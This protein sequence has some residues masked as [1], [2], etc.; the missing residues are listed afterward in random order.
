MVEGEK[1]DENEVVVETQCEDVVENS[2]NRHT[3]LAL[4]KFV[5]IPENEVRKLQGEVESVLRSAKAHGTILLASEGINGTICYPSKEGE[6]DSVV[7]FLDNHQYFKGLRRRP[8]FAN[9]NVFHRLKVKVKEEIV[10]MGD[11]VADEDESL[12]KKSSNPL[13]S[14]CQ[15]NDD[16]HKKVDPTKVVGTYVKPGKEWDN[17]LLDPDVV[18]I[19]TRNK[20]EIE[21]G[22][23]QNAI[24]PHTDN[25]KQFPDWLRRFADDRYGNNNNSNDSHNNDDQEQPKKYQKFEPGD[26]TDTLKLTTTTN[27]R[28]KAPAPYLPPPNLPQKPKAVAM[29][30]TGGIRCEKSTSFALSNK[31]FPSDVP[32]Y[33]LDG[34]ILAYLDKVKASESKWNGECFVFDQRVSL[35]HGL[36]PSEKYNLCYACRRP[37]TV[38]DKHGEDYVKGICC[39]R[40]KNEATDAQKIRFQERQRQIE[41]AKTK[42]IKHIHDPKET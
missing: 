37:I 15:T 38:E 4:Y 18:V 14:S 1:N 28:S 9:T 5:T 29:F 26:D 33:H 19:D 11:G 16:N 17:L 39:K 8:S 12:L 34:G 41:L 13:S 23:F 10:T 21:I 40:C 32:V 42:G 31:L 7:E 6:V 35:T 22:T 27:A 3:V 24:N 36:K 30:C 25:F 20:Y 2:P